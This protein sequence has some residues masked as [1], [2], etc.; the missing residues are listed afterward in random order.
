VP[1]ASEPALSP[2]TADP[3]PDIIVTED[4]WGDALEQLGEG[5][6]VLRRPDAWQSPDQMRQLVSSARG[7]VVRNRTPVDRVLLESGSRLEIV[8]RAGVGLDNID[9]VAA[10][11]LGIVV[12]AAFG[13]NA[14]SVA[15]HALA[16][17]LG[18][19][20]DIPGNDRR[21]RSGEWDRRL[22]MELAG[23]TWGVVGL[24]ATGA[25]VAS[26]ASAIGMHVIGFDPYLPADSLPPSVGERVVGL[27]ELLD[28][29]DVVS[30]HLP[31]TPETAGIVDTSFLEAMR[32]GSHLINVSRGELVDEEAL[33][34]AL[35]R[36]HLAGAG[37]DVRMAEPPSPGRLDT[38]E[39]VI[40]SPHIA[41]LTHEAQDQVATMLAEDLG[42]VL[43]GVDARHA[44]GKW[45]LPHR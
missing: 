33:A 41:G 22:G 12:V 4:V 31:L 20:R 16:L 36:G 6:S 2:P 28:R 14:R 38:C 44:A 42:L 19:A 32:P 3:D 9:V 1:E 34:D 21:V 7:L 29:A 25:A 18:L 45:R 27:D 15:E 37:L 10:D 39:R 35:D 17:A 13:A 23:R 11:E 5:Y 26:V 30:L 43:G 8:A 40:L 24:G